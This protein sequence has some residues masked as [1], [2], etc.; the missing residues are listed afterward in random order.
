MKTPYTTRTG[1]QIGCM[2]EPPRQQMTADEERMQAALLGLRDDP[3]WLW[4]T[5]SAVLVTAL[6]LMASCRGST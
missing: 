3:L 6:I 2:Y 1:I 5:V 4:A